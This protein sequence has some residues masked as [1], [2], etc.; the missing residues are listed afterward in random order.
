MAD[1]VIVAILLLMIGMAVVY[2]RKAK[3]NG[4]KCIGCPSGAV[5]G[6]QK[7]AASGCSCSG[8]GEGKCCCHADTKE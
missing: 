7:I 4:V 3:K 1:I 6:H 2:L 8:N 5:C